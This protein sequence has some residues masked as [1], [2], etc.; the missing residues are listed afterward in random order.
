MH[1]LQGRNAWRCSARCYPGQWQRLNGPR[2]QS[3]PE[4]A[5]ERPPKADVDLWCLP[6]HKLKYL[7]RTFR[8]F[9]DSKVVVG[10]CSA[11]MTCNDNVQ[12]CCNEQAFENLVKVMNNNNWKPVDGQW[13]SWTSR[14]WNG[15]A[16]YLAVRARRARTD[17]WGWLRKTPLRE[18]AQLIGWADGSAAG[19]AGGFG[20]V[21]VSRGPN[22]A[23]IELE[24][25]GGGW[26]P[27]MNSM[28]SENLGFLGLSEG[29]SRRT[30]GLEVRE[31]WGGCPAE[32]C[33][34]TYKIIL[35]QLRLPKTGQWRNDDE[36]HI[37]DYLY[38]CKWH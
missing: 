26:A 11:Q 6:Y 30:S 29:L 27:Q 5:P 33:G 7:P 31:N 24:G 23:S 3:P 28:S 14:Y 8:L 9:L 22:R 36:E 18:D 4:S 13:A 15:T 19:D 17:R 21:I 37:L 25:V 10:W 12:F 38:D 1:T 32:L 35:H 20:W 16:D 2:V 34:K